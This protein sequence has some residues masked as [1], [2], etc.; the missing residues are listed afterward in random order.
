MRQPRDILIVILYYRS[1]SSG[2]KAKKGCGESVT[3][4]KTIN[5]HYNE[6]ISFIEWLR[7][8]CDGS[9]FYNET[10]IVGFFNKFETDVR[11]KTVN[12][13]RSIK[14]CEDSR[15]AYRKFA[16]SETI[17][18][19]PRRMREEHN[20]PLYYSEDV[21]EYL[22]D[23]G[24]ESGKAKKIT[25][26]ITCGSYK[27]LCRCTNI[28]NTLF[29]LSKELHDF[30]KA[31][32]RLPSRSDLVK[33]FYSQYIRFSEEYTGK[34]DPER[35]RIRDACKEKPQIDP[36]VQFRGVSFSDYKQM[37]TIENSTIVCL[38]LSGENELIFADGKHRTIFSVKDGWGVSDGKLYAIRLG[39]YLTFLHSQT[40]KDLKNY[41]KSGCDYFEKM[42]DESKRL[43]YECVKKTVKLKGGFI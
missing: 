34:R 24:M 41:L 11:D 9:E 4:T 39:F 7:D 32:S 33:A 43:K 35:E 40:K 28:K 23:L 29:P 20:L 31:V 22:L 13:L 21:Y 25:E 8:N 6:L 15:E 1:I 3:E 12:K 2:K 37:P 14:R 38:G 17:G 5:L 18:C 30:A 36:G 27:R 19:V 26:T 16:L 42:S 10:H